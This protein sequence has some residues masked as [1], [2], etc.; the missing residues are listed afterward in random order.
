MDIC[1]SGRGVVV[2]LL[3]A[4]AGFSVIYLILYIGINFLYFYI[5]KQLENKNIDLRDKLWIFIPAFLL[6]N[7]MIWGYSFQEKGSL[8]LIIGNSLQFVKSLIAVLS[9]FILFSFCIAW[10]YYRLDAVKII[11]GKN[12]RGGYKETDI[13]WHRYK[14]CFIKHPFLVPFITLFIF[15]IPYIII[16]YPGILNGDGISMIAQAYNY[17]EWTSDY[18]NLIDKN[19]RLNGHHPVLF[20][21]YIHICLKIGSKLFHSYNAGLFI[22]SM[23]QLFAALSAIA[24]VLMFLTK[25]KVNFG[26]ITFLMIYYTISPREQ[27]YMFLISKDIL[28]TYA[29]LFFVLF[30]FKIIVDEENKNIKNYII[31]IISA[32][33]AG[34]LRNDGKYIIFGSLLFMVLFEKKKRK[35]LVISGSIAMFFIMT[36]FHIMMPVLHIT[37]TSRREAL[38]VPFQQTARYVKYVGNEVTEEEKEAISAVL[39]YE[40]LAE[41]YNPVKSDSVKATFNE[42]ATLDDLKNYFK[43]WLQMLFKHPVIYIEAT[44]NNYYNY[45]YPGNV[46]AEAYTYNWSRICMQDIVADENLKKIDMNLHYSDIQIRLQTVYETLRERIFSFPVIG[47]FICPA[48]FVWI[49]FIWLCYLIWL[50]Y[51]RMAGASVPL[52]FSLLIALL[53]PC[54]GEY[55]RYLYGIMV[56]LPVVIILGLEA[57]S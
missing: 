1:E 45:F 41:K 57:R 22:V 2:Q 37:P 56:C 27:N 33:F 38:S 28:F 49:L 9:Y 53:G 16:S 46:L 55:F 51:W 3:D 43:V 24:F 12:V 54:N 8:V 17:P 31:L 5:L 19:V 15:Y 7:F 42:N 20:T 14:R 52:L 32:V 30:Y 11:S 13:L 34:L 48:A 40:E 10:V 44:M 35:Q 50:K 18:L 29:L 6:A 36:F 26:V 23:T 25:R 4:I 21:Y 39:D 47:L